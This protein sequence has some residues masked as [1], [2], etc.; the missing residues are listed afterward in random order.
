MNRTLP[1]QFQ[2]LALF[3]T[4]LTFSP[5]LCTA[6]SGNGTGRKAATTPDAAAQSAPSTV[7]SAPASPTASPLTTEPRSEPLT[8]APLPFMKGEEAQSAEAPS[9]VGL[10]FRTA[11]ALLLIVGLIMAAAWGM[12]RFSGGRFM[13]KD[14]NAP[15]LAV[16]STVPLGDRRSLS[17][18]KFG[19]RTL[20]LGSTQQAITLLASDSQEED[21]H[22]GV[23]RRSVAD[24]LND[25]EI[26]NFDEELAR[27]EQFL[28][29]Q[30]VS[31][32]DEVN[33]I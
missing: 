33:R 26:N 10:L 28:P 31:W 20:L 2:V 21:L 19:E 24:L 3:I 13:N 32:R 11:G 7:D 18:V 4:C 27:A 8:N 17:I 22:A 23:I 9:A 14:G 29:G 5:L 15:Q 1:L 6:Q 25:N 12:R 30:A 16:L